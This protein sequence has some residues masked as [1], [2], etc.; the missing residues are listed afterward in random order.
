MNKY[1]FQG[2]D[3]CYYKET[4][5]NGMTVYL[6][7]YKNKTNYSMHYV[8][9]FGSVDIAFVPYGE[10][11]EIEVPA[12]IA[13]FLEHQKFATEGDL[14][15]FSKAAQTGSDCNAATYPTSTRYL[16]EG[17]KGFKENLDYLLTYVH[18]PYF[19][20]EGVEKERGIIVEELLQYEDVVEYKLDNTIKEALL[21][22]DPLRI[23]IGGTVET[24]KK[25]TK[26]QLDITYQ[27]FYQ[28]SNMFLVISGPFDP[29]EAMEVIKNNQALQNAKTKH[30]IKRR[31]YQEPTS[32]NEPRVEINF[33]TT[34]T[35]V[36]YSLKIDISKQEDKFTTDIYFSL[37]LSILFGISSDFRERMKQQNMYTSFYYSKETSGDYI[38]ISFVAES[39]KPEELIEEIKKE[40]KEFNLKEEEL[41]RVKKVWISSEVMMIDN[42]NATL[43]NVIYDVVEYGDVIANKIEIFKKLNL[44]DLEK[45][46][47]ES[48]LSNDSIVIIRPKKEQK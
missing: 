30:E 44:K 6:I 24:I 27:T 43:D 13:H 19:T 28:P 29:E 47:R 26:E 22:K 14:D 31:N 32:V 40:L 25:I 15:P 12:G 1:E 10:E 16:F 45:L 17:N 33:N 5:D 37:M 42:I 2:L 23:D 9:K 34:N 20:Q 36:A 3:Q 35:K 18:T 48:D 8:T 11:E 4:L 21:V 39:E 38:L 41:E 7:P 46:L